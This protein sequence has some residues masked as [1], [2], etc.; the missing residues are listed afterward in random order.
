MN[1][2]LSTLPA[3]ATLVELRDAINDAADNPGVQAAIIRTGSDVKLVLNSEKTGA[4]NLVSINLSGGSGTQYNEL[5]SAISTKTQLATAQDAKFTFNGIA[6]TSDTNKVENVVN[7]LSLTLS[8]TNVGTPLTLTVGRDD[9][10]IIDNMTSLVDAYNSL[11]EEVKLATLNAE[12]RS[13]VLSGDSTV[14]NMSTQLRSIFSSLPPGT[15]LSDLGLS[16]DKKG[17]LTLDSKK[18]SEGL[19]VNPELLNT[20]LLGTDGIV[21]RL[22]EKL[23]PYSKTSGIFDTKVSSLNA[24]VTRVNDATEQ[25]DLRMKNSYNRYLLQFSQYNMLET[26]MQQTASLFTV[27]S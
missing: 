11:N 14:R 15:Y 22:A 10:T 26:Q 27:S 7:N 16:F 23:E 6:I 12:D 2:D 4:A 17:T 19:D 8:Q 24:E 20:S 3:N 18:L 9:D 5:D 1:L 13:P 25:L 21:T